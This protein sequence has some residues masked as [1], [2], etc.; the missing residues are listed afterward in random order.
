MKH[1][2]IYIK[3]T[4]IFPGKPLAND[5]EAEILKNIKD[6]GYISYTVIVKDFA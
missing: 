4:F 6:V 3:N 1:I 5:G 2:C